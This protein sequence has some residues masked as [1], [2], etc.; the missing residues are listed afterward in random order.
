M[1]KC[2]KCNR[3][4]KRQNQQHY[5]GEKPTSINEYIEY[6]EPEIKEHLI[7][8]RNTISLAIP[9]AKER[10]T[11][12]MPTYWDGQNIIHFAAQKKHIGIYA[13]E[14]TVKQFSNKLDEMGLKY[15]KGTIQI[16]YSDT[17]P[18][19]LISDIAKWNY[20]EV[21]NTIKRCYEFDA[22][23]EPVLDKGGAF[24][25]VPID[26]RSEFG[27]GRLKV[28]AEFE[29]IKYD[30]SV[31]NMGVTNEDGSICY[32]IGVRKD[33]QKLIKKGAGDTIHIKIIPIL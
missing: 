21:T 12:S 20:E 17:M 6:C 30:G 7:L 31:V 16:P 9:K 10:M 28:H 19:D 15:N 33:I 1:W 23:I 5:C 22:V 24:V 11:W 4:F 25:R 29:G 8:V 14:D 3:E 2:P 26:I 27:K 13:G 18:L 32:I